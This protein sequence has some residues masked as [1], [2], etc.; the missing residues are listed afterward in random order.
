LFFAEGE[1]RSRAAAST[2]LALGGDDFTLSIWKNTRHKPLV[3]FTDLFGRE[4]LD[5]G[6]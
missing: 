2:I 4:I 5:L 6:W 3:V 1:P